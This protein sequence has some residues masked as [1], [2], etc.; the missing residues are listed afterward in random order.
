MGK[1]TESCRSVKVSLFKQG[2]PVSLTVHMAVFLSHTA[3]VAQGAGCSR[4][5]VHMAVFLSHAAGVA[6]GAGCS[7]SHV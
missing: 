7:R 1:E 2:S 5:T 4:L 3:G 6:Q